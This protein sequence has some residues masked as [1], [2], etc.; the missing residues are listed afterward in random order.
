MSE[1]ENVLNTEN[2][3]FTNYRVDKIFLFNNDYRNGE[4]YEAAGAETLKAGTLL[5][6]KSAAPGKLVK[7]ASGSV[8][9]SEKPVGIVVKDYAIAGAGDVLVAICIKGDVDAGMLVFDGS[10]TLKTVVD[11]K[12]YQD[13]LTSIRNYSK[14]IY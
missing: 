6:R 4:T 13:W 7:M 1:F 3:S 9:G 5:G 8:D 2:Q 12:Q 10:D 11:G 14:R